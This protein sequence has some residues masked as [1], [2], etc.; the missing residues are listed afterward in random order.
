MYSPRS[1]GYD[2]FVVECDTHQKVVWPCGAAM[3]NRSVN[4]FRVLLV[5]SS[6]VLLLV[7]CYDAENV[8]LEHEP[9]ATFE[10]EIVEGKRL[11]LHHDGPMC[12]PAWR[13]NGRPVSSSRC[14]VS[15]GELIFPAVSRNDAGRYDLWSGDGKAHGTSR[16]IFSAFVRV[17]PDTERIVLREPETRNAPPRM[18]E[19]IVH[20]YRER[21]WTDCFC[22]G[23]TERC[24]MAPNL[25]RARVT[26]NLTNAATVRNR[27]T[28]FDSTPSSYLQIPG[29]VFENLITAYGGYLRFPL[30]E[31]CYTDRSKPCLVITHKRFVHRAI[32]FYLPRQHD[33]RPVQVPMTEPNWKLLTLA[34]EDEHDPNRMRPM[35]LD[36]FNFLRVLTNIG[37]IYIR[38][39]LRARS[40]GNE[41]SVD[42]A[43]RT[44]EGLGTVTTVEQCD[45]HEGYVGLSC[46]RCDTDY[47]PL[48]GTVREDGVCIHLLDVWESS[49]R[50]YGIS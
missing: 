13:H 41:L 44:D 27:T 14:K 8:S 23:V 4:L 48:Y 25:Y 15:H 32:A 6:T 33:Q 17:V 1:E 9:T 11:R 47:L 36:K 34:R 40:D 46:E 45:C 37:T 50:K 21:W 19:P 22:S 39:G 20:R 31:E 49:K 28:P 7:C 2:Q 43:S 24:K 18:V 26:F 5:L 35:E 10:V 30:T 42:V 16:L 29:A 38:G 3:W 12:N